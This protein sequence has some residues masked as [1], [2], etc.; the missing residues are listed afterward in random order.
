MNYHAWTT[1]LDE[2]G[3]LYPREKKLPLKERQARERER[4]INYPFRDPL[5]RLKRITRLD[6]ENDWISEGR[7]Y[8]NI[9]PQLVPQLTR[10]KLDGIRGHDIEIPGDFQVVNLRFAEPHPELKNL[11]SVL[12]SKTPTGG[13]RLFA[14]FGQRQDVDGAKCSLVV[15]LDPETLPDEDLNTAFDRFHIHHNGTETEAKAYLESLR[16][17][18]RLAVAVGFLANADEDHLLRY[19][20][21]AADRFNYEEAL[22]RGN[23]IRAKALCDKAKRRG[24]LGW[25]VGTTEIL[26]GTTTSQHRDTTSS[27]RELHYSHIR[28]GHFHA[29]RFGEGKRKVKLKWFRPTQVRPDLPFNTG[30]KRSTTPGL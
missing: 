17:F 11:Q 5:V 15:S 19:D 22:C 29:V 4:I 9:H 6:L 13:F 2:A 14:D 1:F 30:D 18:F 21:L 20:V 12:L 23:T 28:T 26:M 16:N 8:Y 10:C 24:K 25:N 27:D 3:L 7:P